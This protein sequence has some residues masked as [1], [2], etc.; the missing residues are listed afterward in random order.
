MLADQQLGD[1]KP[2]AAL[3]QLQRLAPNNPDIVRFRFIEMMPQGVQ[4]ILASLSELSV[5]KLA[6]TADKLVDQI[7]PVPS[8]GAVASI[9]APAALPDPVRVLQDAT[10]FLSNQMSTLC[11]KVEAISSTFGRSRS[12]S[13]SPQFRSRAFSR[14]RFDESGQYCW[15]HFTFGRQAK[16]C[17][18]SPCLMFVP[19][20]H[21]G[22]DATPSSSQP[23]PGS[24]R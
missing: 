8:T 21:S 15:Y 9:N 24:T 12:R 23:A 17:H 18:G 2:S 3:R 4:L 1:R 22:N 19:A 16:K 10:T 13:T 6:E 14:E 20:K 7:A 5:E 11:A